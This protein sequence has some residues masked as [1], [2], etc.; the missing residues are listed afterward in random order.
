MA[1]VRLSRR[2][3]ITTG[4]ATCVA[5]AAGIGY[6]MKTG[7]IPLPSR[8]ERL[9]AD[10]GPDGVIPSAPPGQES[11]DQ[12]YSAARGR[13]VSFYT[14]VPDGF[15]D[16]HG[17]PVCLIMHGASA[18]ADSFAGFG[19][20]RYLT[21]AVQRGAEPFVLAGA[22]GNANG[23]EGTSTDHPMD[24]VHDEV[25]R[26]C[27]ARG[28]DISRMAIWAWSM[29]GRGALGLA[30]K[31]PGFVR[32]VA[33]FSPAI[34]T[35]GP[36]MAGVDRLRDTKIGLWCGRSDGLYP[37]VKEFAQKLPT[38]PV[39]AAFGRGAHTRGYW[40]RVTPAAFQFLAT[41]LA[42]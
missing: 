16:G 31:Y 12:M 14:A 37:A 42:A 26:W 38:P 6:G 23:W 40:D 41:E 36:E 22:T 5:G 29:G 20:G 9:V 11:V 24:M 13:T 17:L 34:S 3:F 18:T 30:E 8:V 15:G 1:H 28:C 4:L 2:A 7:A 39:I 33:A 10:Q 21:D 32:A 25:P 27:A 35:D 19:F